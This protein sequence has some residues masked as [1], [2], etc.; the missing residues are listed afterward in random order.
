MGLLLAVLFWP[1]SQRWARRNPAI[2]FFILLQATAMLVDAV[3]DLQIGLNFFV[4]G[5][6]FL[7]VAGERM[8]NEQNTL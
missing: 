4:F 1:L 2:G 5:Y 7:V 6:G 3:L 8:R